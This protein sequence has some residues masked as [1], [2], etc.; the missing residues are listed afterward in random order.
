M[1]VRF[2]VVEPAQQGSSPRLGTD[3]R[4]FLDL[5]QDLTGAIVTVVGNVAV[6]IEAPV[7]T[8][9]ILRIC[10]LSLSEVFI[11]VGLHAYIH[12]GECGCVC[13]RLRLYCISQKKY[14]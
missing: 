6:D 7:V 14:N 9:S 3:A 11:G 5:F 10:Q 8:S 1:S 12:R 2:H 4:I 13:E